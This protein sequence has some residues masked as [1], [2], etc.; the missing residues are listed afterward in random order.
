MAHVPA[1]A[2]P[3]AAQP[4]AGLP[5]PSAAPPLGIDATSELPAQTPVEDAAPAT[6]TGPGWW[7]AMKDNLLAIDRQAAAANRATARAAA[8]TKIAPKAVHGASPVPRSRPQHVVTEP[9]GPRQRPGDGAERQR[10]S[11]GEQQRRS[12]G[13]EQQRRGEGAEA[14]TT[15]WQP[16]ANREP[17]E[18]S[19]WDDY[20]MAEAP[21]WPYI[22]PSASRGQ[23]VVQLLGAT[24]VP[25]AKT[26]TFLAI[27][28]GTIL[29]LVWLLAG[30]VN[31]DALIVVQGPTAATPSPGSTSSP[32][33][34][35]PGSATPALPTAP[36][37]P[38]ARHTPAMASGAKECTPGVWA[39]QQT[40]CVLAGAVAAQVRLDMTSPVI[41]EAFSTTSNRSY[42]LECVA[43]QGITCTG[44]DGVEGVVI[45]LVAPN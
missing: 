1:V 29:L 6:R 41:V 23:Q 20:G 44:L 13:A 14:E 11:D 5:V 21:D 37:P 25:T 22:D 4:A 8:D 30:L 33:P 34:L 43:G 42:R 26:A 15:A 3:A 17:G 38:P 36:T 18:L 40:S 28:G 32:A 35:R 9:D 45:W 24:A 27:L 7:H 16:R 31:L 10:R 39:G 2:P 19:L 12:D